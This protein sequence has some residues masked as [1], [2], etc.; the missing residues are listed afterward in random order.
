M[1]KQST[2]ILIAVLALAVAPSVALAKAGNAAATQAYI[3]ANYAFVRASRS[4][5]ATGQAAIKSLVSE[6]T[7]QCPGA[8]AGSPQ[9]Q[10]SEQLTHE[11]IAALY[12]QIY[13]PEAPAIRVFSKAVKGLHWSNAKLTHAV[14]TYATKLDVLSALGTPGICSDVKAWA[15]T[16]FQTLPESTASFDRTYNASELEAEEVPLKLLAPYESHSAASL[17][18]RTE[19]LEAPLAE[20]E[21]KAVSDYSEIL[22]GLG[23]HP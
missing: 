16:G 15:T 11:V 13:R 20:A 3:K 7:G 22:D 8:A 9:D 12:I 5:L 19:Q 14:R 2:L 6:I 23:L 1:A 4:E 10:D 21:A 18:H 17:L